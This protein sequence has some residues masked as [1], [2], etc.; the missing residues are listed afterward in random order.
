MKG[1][2]R[3]AV[4]LVMKEGEGEEA[5]GAGGPDLL[6]VDGSASC[7]LASSFSGVLRP[8]VGGGAVAGLMTGLGGKAGFPA[9]SCADAL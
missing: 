3:G 8:D 4:V 6:G 2:A 7:I 5:E 9:D 1:S